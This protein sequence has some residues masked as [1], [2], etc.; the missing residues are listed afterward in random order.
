MK[1][2][3]QLQNNPNFRVEMSIIKTEGKHLMHECKTRSFYFR[4]NES[5]GVVWKDK[6][7]I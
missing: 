1:I 2:A 6:L 7:N 4:N 3:T 5:C